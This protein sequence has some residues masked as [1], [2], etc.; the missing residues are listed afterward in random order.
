M[1]N[2]VTEIEGIEIFVDGNGKFNADVHGRKI[3]RTTLKAVEKVILDASQPLKVFT[4]AYS[5]FRANEDNIIGIERSG[6]ARTVAGELLG[7][8]EHVYLFDQKI[9][10]KLNELEEA[11]RELNEQSREV[12]KNA[13]EVT[14]SNFAELRDAQNAD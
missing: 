4:K 7:K 6:K 1:E 14:G 5:G 3:S 10:D 9:Y 13:V 2:K 8:Y 12:M 11:R